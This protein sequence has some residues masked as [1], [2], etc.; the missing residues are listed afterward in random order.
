MIGENVEHTEIVS[1]GGEQVPSDIEERL[2]QLSDE[3]L[4]AVGSRARRIVYGRRDERRKAGG[5]GARWLMAQRS[6]CHRCKRCRPSKEAY[7]R[8]EGSLERIHGPYWY[9]ETY[10]PAAN[11][12]TAPSGERRSGRNRVRYIGRYLP[13]DLAQEFG[14]EEGATPEAAGYAE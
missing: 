4:I 9:L 7:D 5:E 2:Q 13:A 12:Y 6:N 14:L 1:D 8:G 11:T 3:E 10:I